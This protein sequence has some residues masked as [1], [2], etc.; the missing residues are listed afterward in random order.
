MAQYEAPSQ[1][2]NSQK[3]YRLEPRGADVAALADLWVAAWQ[4]VMP[5]I[6]FAAR[7]SW[8]IRC[9]ADVEAQGGTTVC[10]YDGKGEVAGFFLLDL[11]RAYLEQIAIAPLLFGSGLARLLIGEAQ[12]LCPDGLTLDVNADNLRALRFYEKAGFQRGEAGVNPASG[13]ATWR[14]HWPSPV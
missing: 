5:Q 10:A 8:L 13:L 4:A 3:R 1:K 7:R 2:S 12:R 14:M 11:S 6:D 9:V